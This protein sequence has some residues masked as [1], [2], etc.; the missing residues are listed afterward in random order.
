MR[1]L[2]IL[3]DLKVHKSSTEETDAS[4]N[5]QI[6]GQQSVLEDRIHRQFKDVA[7]SPNYKRKPL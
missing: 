4:V 7:G 2:H 5:Q 6:K 3:Y 1:K